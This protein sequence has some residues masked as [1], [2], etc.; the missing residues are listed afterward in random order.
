MLSVFSSE[1]AGIGLSVQEIDQ[2]GVVTRCAKKNYLEVQGFA[3]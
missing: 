1:F 2:G 3:V